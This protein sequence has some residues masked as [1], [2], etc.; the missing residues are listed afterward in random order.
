MSANPVLLSR[1]LPE[2]K[3]AQ[4]I[5]DLARKGM[6]GKQIRNI[7]CDKTNHQYVGKL[8]DKILADVDSY[9]TLVDDVAV[10]RAYMGDPV[11]WRAC[12]R[13]ERAACV[14]RL[15]DRALLGKDHMRWSGLEPTE[16][17]GANGWVAEWA[18]SVGES[19]LRIGQILVARRARAR[20]AA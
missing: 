11:A 14:D 3:R 17:G 19:P 5:V 10:Q 12:T 6:T 16:W 20:A 18:L 13:Y 4:R 7:V 9:D 15:M 1:V 2:P 8:V